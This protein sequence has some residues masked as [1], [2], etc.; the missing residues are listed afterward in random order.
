[1]NTFATLL[2]LLP[3]VLF[4]GVFLGFILGSFLATVA[5]ADA[6]DPYQQSDFEHECNAPYPRLGD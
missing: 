5:C 4:V 1:M 2:V 3:I 6:N